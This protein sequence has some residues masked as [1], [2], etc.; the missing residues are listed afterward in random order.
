MRLTGAA[1]VACRTIGALAVIPVGSV[2]D[3]GFID[4]C[5][6]TLERAGGSPQPTE[7]PR[8]LGAWRHVD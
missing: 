3:G 5:G 1:L 6:M 2:K 7:T 8:L 4:N